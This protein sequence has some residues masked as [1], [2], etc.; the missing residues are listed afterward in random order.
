MTTSLAYVEFGSFHD[1]KKPRQQIL[2]NVNRVIAFGNVHLNHNRW[3]W[4]SVK[5]IYNLIC[6]VRQRDK[7][8][9]QDAINESDAGSLS[10]CLDLHKESLSVVALGASGLSPVDVLPSCRSSQH[11]VNLWTEIEDARFYI[12]FCVSPSSHLK[13]RFAS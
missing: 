11:V 13:L 12:L 1:T 8:N 4:I 5:W 2:G 9:F 10:P 3:E 6:R 7:S